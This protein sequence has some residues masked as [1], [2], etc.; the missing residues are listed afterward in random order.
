MCINKTTVQNLTVCFCKSSDLKLFGGSRLYSVKLCALEAGLST[1]LQ[2]ASDT[3]LVYDF[4]SI[5]LGMCIQNTKKFAFIA[6]HLANTL[7]TYR[8]CL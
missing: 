4:K 6:L 2:L 5:S 8:I 3:K 7:P 1:R